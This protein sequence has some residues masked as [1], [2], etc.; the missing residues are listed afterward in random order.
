MTDKP[1]EKEPDLVIWKSKCGL[2]CK[3][4]RNA[5]LG[6]WLGYVG[7]PFFNPLFGKN[8][9]EKEVEALDVHGGIS[10][11]DTHVINT[12]WFF[13]FDCG[14]SEDLIPLGFFRALMER[15]KAEYRDMHYAMSEC[16]RLAEQIK[17]FNKVSLAALINSTKTIIKN[18]R[19][20]KRHVI[21]TI[22]KDFVGVVRVPRTVGRYYI[23]EQKKSFKSKFMI[24]W[25]DTFKID[26][27][28]R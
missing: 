10:F 5:Q 4:M 6:F 27:N 23:D 19:R 8:S 17:K 16:E 3:I 28:M 22:P 26:S 11:A 21:R 12:N 25:Q 20:V 1:W 9:H 14:H 15:A 2:L 18:S 13:G 24:N 7:V